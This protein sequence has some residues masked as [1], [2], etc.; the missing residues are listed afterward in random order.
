MPPFGIWKGVDGSEV[1]AIF[2]GEAYDAHKQYNKDMS[3]DEDMNRLA[4]ENYQKYGLA[5]VFRYVGPM[6]D[7]GGGLKDTE[8]EEGER[9]P[10]WLQQSINS[11][12]PVKVDLWTPDAI[13]QY[14]DENRNEKYVVWDNELPMKTHG[15]GCYTSQTIMKYWNRKNELLA[16]ATEKASVA[17]AWVGGAEYPSDILTESWIRLLWHQFHDDLTGTSIP[18]AYTISYNDEVLVN[19]T[20]A[21][22]LTGTIGALVRQMDT[23]VQGVPLVVYNPL[24]V[25]RTDV[26]EASIT[27]ASE[28]SEI[29]I[30]DGAGEE[31]L[32]Q[33]TGYDSTTGKLSFI[34]KATVAS[35]GYAT[36]EIRLN[37]TSEL[38][39]SLKITE[40]T[41]ENDR[42]LVTLNARTGDVR[43]IK[44]KKLDKLLLRMPIQMLLF[45][46][47]SDSF[48]AWEIVYETLN[49]TPS[50]VDENV[51]IEIVENGPLRVSLKICRTK[52]L[53]EL[54]NIYV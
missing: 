18:S 45:D 27:V 24:S 3:K 43:Q 34:F 23:Q 7:R 2:K 33:I 51:K 30:L 19:Q 14:L 17:A 28:P 8:S 20:L 15:T 13:F 4:E 52:G 47:R 9:T 40:T 44:D 38:S 49:N 25:Q 48:P 54:Y 12:G 32:S 16:D 26:V 5:S 11:D 21:N 39:S 1:Y 42:Y 46:D 10:Y 31:V 35:L 6:G 22:T 53:S 41:L 37:E 29:R 36:Y 50:Y